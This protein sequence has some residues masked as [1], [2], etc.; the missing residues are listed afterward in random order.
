MVCMLAGG[1][2]S[3]GSLK[4]RHKFDDISFSFYTRAGVSTKSQVAVGGNVRKSVTLGGTLVAAFFFASS[5]AR[6][7]AVLYKSM[8][9]STMSAKKSSYTEPCRSP[10][11]ALG[12][13]H[14]SPF[15]SSSLTPQLRGQ[16]SMR[17]GTSTLCSFMAR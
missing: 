7:R 1:L 3:C 4:I 8:S 14:R 6:W 13:Q 12:N 17:S 11:T 9:C 16:P 10:V 15:S 2:W 5:S